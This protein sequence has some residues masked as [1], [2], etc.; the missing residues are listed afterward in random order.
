VR[1]FAAA[2]RQYDNAEPPECDMPDAPQMECDGSEDVECYGCGG[3]RR[4]RTRY[5]VERCDVCS[6][7]GVV[8]CGGCSACNGECMPASAVQVAAE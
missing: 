2:Q 1:G 4:R 6:G 5:G 7:A 8:P 3:S